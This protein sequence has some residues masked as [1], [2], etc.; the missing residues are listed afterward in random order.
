MTKSK[1]KTWYK[2]TIP[3]ELEQNVEIYPTGE[4]DG[5]VVVTKE[6]GDDTCN[7][8]LYLNPAE[9]NLL[10]TKMSE[11]MAYVTKEQNP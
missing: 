1:N 8:R 6:A 9:M 3:L 7:A 11:M 2:V 10:I 5:I 4:F